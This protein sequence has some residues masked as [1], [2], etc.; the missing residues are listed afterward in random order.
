MSAD[1]RTRAGA[2]AG[3]DARQANELGGI[4]DP[5]EGRIVQPRM[6]SHLLA[7]M[8]ERDEMAGEVSADDRR[9]ILLFERS[10]APGVVPVVDLPAKSL[11]SVHRLNRDLET[12]TRVDGADASHTAA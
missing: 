5:G 9:G 12:L 10:A 4:V 6:G 8:R 1:D 7:G 2:P 3:L 11:D